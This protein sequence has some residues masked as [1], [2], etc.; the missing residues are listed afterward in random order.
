MTWH[1]L[2]QE[3]HVA[4]AR[5]AVMDPVRRVRAV[6][7]DVDRVLTARAL[8]PSEAL[9]L[10]RTDAAARIPHHL[11]LRHLLQALLDDPD[12]L[13]ALRDTDPVGGLDVARRIGNDLELQLGVD[14][15]WIVEP[16]VEVHAGAAQGRAGHAHLDCLLLRHLPDVARAGDEDLVP[17]DQVDEVPLEVVLEA[18]DVVPDLLRYIRRKVGLDAP[19]ADVVEHHPRARHGLEDGL[20]TL[21]LAESVEDR[22]E[23]PE[24]EH[25]EADGWDVARQPHELA[26]E[27]ADVFGPRRYLHVEQ[28][29][30][31]EARSR[32]RCACWRSSRACRSEG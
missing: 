5:V 13:Q 20:Y 14:A 16:D 12:A 2:L 17:L 15:V 11:A 7:D 22:G 21:P 27:D 24:L 29:L 10:G 30:D 8:D 1:D 6:R 26:H 32:A 31:R 19:D 4:E 3:L 9:A 25:E 23:S 28:V 18:L